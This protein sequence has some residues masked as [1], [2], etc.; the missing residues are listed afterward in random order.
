MIGPRVVPY[1]DFK[2]LEL[3]KCFGV[4]P[5]IVNPDGTVRCNLFNL[6]RDYNIRVLCP[7][8]KR[9]IKTFTR[10]KSAPKFVWHQKSESDKQMIVKNAINYYSLAHYCINCIYENAAHLNYDVTLKEFLGGGRNFIT[11][12]LLA[13]ALT[14]FIKNKL[15]NG[16]KF[17]ASNKAILDN[18]VALT[19]AVGIYNKI[20]VPNDLMPEN[21]IIIAAQ[22]GMTFDNGIL[23]CPLIYKQEFNRW[24]FDND[25]SDD[26]SGEKYRDYPVL[27]ECGM[28]YKLYERFINEHIPLEWHLEV[29][30]KNVKD[31]YTIIHLKQ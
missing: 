17:V 20:L 21:D 18:F 19:S 28:R 1:I 24:L 16:N 9:C 5:I 7:E 10:L 25:I 15:N 12:R 31:F 13:E 27:R 14:L 30:E 22:G 3:S 6:I 11:N 4:C 8:T 2:P 26:F 23:L 29:F